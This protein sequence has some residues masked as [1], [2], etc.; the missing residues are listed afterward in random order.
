M[1]TPDIVV[2]GH[3]CMDLFPGFNTGTD[4]IED[5]LKPGKLINVGPMKNAT[6]GVVPNTG[7]AL[8][9]FGLD[10]CLMGKV[11]DDV[12]GQG[13]LEQM[14]FIGMNTDG[15][16][17]EKGAASSY[18]IVLNIPGLDRIPLHYPGL[19]D[20]FCAD[21]LD[22]PTLGKA[23]HFHFGYPPLMRGMFADGGEQLTEIFRRV[24][25]LGLTTSLDMARPDPDTESGK[26]D[27]RAILRNVLPF[28]DLFTP[29][30]DELLYM[31]DR[32]AFEAF[33]AGT[34]LTRAQLDALG[35]ELIGMGAKAIFM[36]LGELGAYYYS[37]S[38]QVY[39]P[40]FDVELV[41]AIGSGDC[42]IA[43]FLAA[44][45]RG[46]SAEKSVECAV[47]AGACN[48]ESSTQSLSALIIDLDSRQIVYEASVNFDEALPHYGTQN[49][50]L[51]TAD[52][53]VVHSPPLMWVEALDVLLQKMKNDGAPLGDVKAIS[54]SGQQ[55]GSVYLN[56]TAPTVL[57]NLTA[58]QPLV[59]QLRGI[60]SRET[61]PIWMDSSTSAECEEI[62]A[63]LGGKA[64][65][66]KATGSA[67][68]ER[69]TG[70]Q[71]R[72]F[73]KTDSKA[74]EQTEHIALV[75]SFM[76]T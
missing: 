44:Q 20:T 74:F 63:A 13:I 50:T 53:Q 73:A 14:N 37:D 3:T 60:F 55:H 75:S 65:T 68:F 32:P 69:F 36:K 71:I 6:G 4:R 66:A 24:K 52:P 49:G 51:R 62:E 18:T 45:L 58:D 39:S 34:P 2:A 11:G 16:I 21:D 27:W 17:V 15:M 43:G 12:L 46:L 40:C 29:S 42:T 38:E 35:E 23:K 70:P 47:A 9:R 67:A 25:T 54:G 41:G 72:K 64:A 22:F 26:A 10:V 28:V 33:E 57:E 61:S 56:A 7:G 30:I 59:D 19:N 76:G 48:V 31:L 5:F 8:H 1:S